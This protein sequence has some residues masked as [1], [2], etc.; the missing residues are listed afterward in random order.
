MEFGATNLAVPRKISLL[1]ALESLADLRERGRNRFLPSRDATEEELVCPKPR[2]VGTG[3]SSTPL[4]ASAK[5]YRRQR[6]TTSLPA[7]GEAGHEILDILYSKVNSGDNGGSGS[8]NKYINGSP[9][10]RASN[11]M[12][13]D[14][15][16]TQKWTMPS[17]IVIPQK[18]TCSSSSLGGSSSAK[19][20]SS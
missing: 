10:C 14:A 9:P 8:P 1:N 16:F 15:H 3:M 4:D 17:S 12:I 18:S 7:I 19:S 20:N 5:P 13:H 6:G 11:P 2:R